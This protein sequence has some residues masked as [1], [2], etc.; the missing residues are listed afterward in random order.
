MA[1]PNPIIVAK[2][3]LI[4]SITGGIYADIFFNCFI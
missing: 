3:I 2:I 1:R 4:I